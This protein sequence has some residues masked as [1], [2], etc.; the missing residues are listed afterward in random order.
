MAPS[1]IHAVAP[2]RACPTCGGQARTSPSDDMREYFED[3]LG[4][5]GMSPLGLAVANI[6]SDTFSLEASPVRAERRAQWRQANYIEFRCRTALASFDAN[7]LTGLLVR[8]HDACIRM[9]I[10]PLSVK[11]FRITFSRR[12]RTGDL[13]G[14]HP[15]IEQAIE[16]V[17]KVTYFGPRANA[18]QVPAV[19]A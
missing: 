16:R 13:H 19:P 9:E 3:I 11:E 10:R 18:G 7:H 6:I 1:A 12:E 5:T 14:R 15:S 8:C 2:G 4:V 17:R